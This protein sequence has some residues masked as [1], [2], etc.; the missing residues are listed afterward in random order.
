MHERDVIERIF[1]RITQSPT[2]CWLVD[3]WHDGKGYRNVSVDG[4]T[5]KVHRVMFEWFWR[6]KLRKNVQVDHKCCE[7]SCCN[8]AHLQSCR[9]KKN[10][11]LRS[12][13]NG[14]NKG[15]VDRKARHERPE[16]LSPQ[17]IQDAAG[18]DQQQLCYRTEHTEENDNAGI[19]QEM[20]VVAHEVNV[21]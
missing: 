5:C 14:K 17:E 20:P 9:N 21:K 19:L 8:P 4:K 18:S 13:R 7:R 1:K 10:S 11:K 16:L 12:K 3:G 15:A 2:G 6:R